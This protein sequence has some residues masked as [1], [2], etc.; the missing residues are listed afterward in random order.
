MNLVGES[1]SSISRHQA[2]LNEEILAI[3]AEISVLKQEL[4]R[5]QDPERMQLV[6]SLIGVS[7]GLGLEMSDS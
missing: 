1:L 4:L 6:Q 2:A 7:R 3:K 5:D